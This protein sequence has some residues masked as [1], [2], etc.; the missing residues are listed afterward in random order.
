MKKTLFLMFICSFL[1]MNV[2]A[3]DKCGYSDKYELQRKS[4]NV[5]MKYEIKEK[6]IMPATEEYGAVKQKYFEITIFNI[7]DD[8]YAT[9][10]ND[11]T[12]KDEMITSS[13]FKDGIY[14]FEWDE[15]SK[16]T[17]FTLKVAGSSNTN[18]GGEIF[19]TVK[20]T[21]PRRNEYATKGVCDNLNEFYLCQPFV[22]YKSVDEDEFAEQVLKFKDGLI[23]KNGNAE[24]NK[25]LIDKV[26]GFLNKYKWVILGCAIIIAGAGGTY[27]YVRTKKQRDLGL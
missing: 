9:L 25:T 16:V 4:S 26:F 23:D 13:M 12:K 6:E 19:K 5:S 8:F 14:T 21:T 7:T 10:T 22:T 17:N 15:I 20:L 11:V 3:A 18:C 24:E 1:F 27:Y 2:Q